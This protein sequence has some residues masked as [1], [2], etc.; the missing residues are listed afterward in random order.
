MTDAGSPVSYAYADGVARITLTDGDRGNPVDLDSVAALTDAVLRARSDA[1]RVVV[2]AAEGR[3]FSVGGDLAA[4]AGADLV[5]LE[6]PTNPAMEVGDL[7]ALTAAAK[8]AGALVAV[9]RCHPITVAGIIG[10]SPA[11]GD[12]RFAERR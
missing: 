12:H 10:T 9:V 7:P 8:D 4:F 3:F 2:L 11:I 1:A 6:S 5:W